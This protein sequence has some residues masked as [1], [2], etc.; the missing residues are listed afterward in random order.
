MRTKKKPIWPN[1][2]VVKTPENIVTFGTTLFMRDDGL[3]LRVL[4]PA[5]QFVTFA[6]LDETGDNQTG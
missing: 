2:K 3:A 6:P 5:G 4:F 1:Y